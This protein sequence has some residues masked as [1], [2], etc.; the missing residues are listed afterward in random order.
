MSYSTVC[1]V[2]LKITT[3]KNK[4]ET[5]AFYRY[6]TFTQLQGYGR[7]FLR[8]FIMDLYCNK[9]SI[10]YLPSVG[11]K[12]I[13]KELK[14]LMLK[15]LFSSCLLL[16]ISVLYLR[17]RIFCAIYCYNIILKLN[18]E[19]ISCNPYAKCNLGV[20]D[21]CSRFISL[22]IIF[23]YYAFGKNKKRKSG[24]N[25]FVFFIPI[26]LRLSSFMLLII[27]LIIPFTISY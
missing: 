23:P 9:G 8:L 11:Q 2:F 27:I 22:H 16:Y 24:S 18:S 12:C 25:L 4:N 14:S 1:V 19:V 7:G 6:I 21:V 15:Q 20:S 26:T 17:Q 13:T 5:F 10:Y 3:N